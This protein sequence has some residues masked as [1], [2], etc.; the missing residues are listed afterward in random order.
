MKSPVHKSAEQ[1]AGVER[2]ESIER[3]IAAPIGLLKDP[4]GMERKKL[5]GPAEA[6]VLV[7]VDL[8]LV[9]IEFRVIEREPKQLNVGS[10]LRS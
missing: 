3:N 8:I 1:C 9:V 4:S 5:A 10:A 6:D 7:N 2:C